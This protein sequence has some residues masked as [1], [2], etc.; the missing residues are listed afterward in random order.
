MRSLTRFAFNEAMNSSKSGCARSP[1]RLHACDEA[2]VDRVHT[3]FTG[4]LV[5]PRAEVVRLVER[6]QRDGPP[7][8]L[9]I[10]RALSPGHA[11]IVDVRARSAHR[12]RGE[13]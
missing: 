2:F 12:P 10:E 9:S 3:L 6:D 11:V 1:S 4:E 7:P 5:E 13:A 8:S